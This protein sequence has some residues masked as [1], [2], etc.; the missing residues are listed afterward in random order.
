[1]NREDRAKQFAPFDALKGLQ[2]ALR[3]KEIELEEK[4]E[5]TETSLKEL[6]EKFN[7]VKIGKNIKIKFYNDGRYETGE[8]IL[9]QIDYNK[10]RILIEETWI[11]LCDVIEIKIT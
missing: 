6:E 8:G 9:K 3:K 4:K 5:L 10:K 11:N 2:D 7:R 1:M